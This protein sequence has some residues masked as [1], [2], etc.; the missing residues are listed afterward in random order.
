[1]LRSSG[2]DHRSIALL[3]GC[4]HPPGLLGLR[5]ELAACSLRTCTSEEPW[6]LGKTNPEAVTSEPREPASE[7]S[8]L[9]TTSPSSSCTNERV[10][11]RR[12]SVAATVAPP[13]PGAPRAD[14]WGIVAIFKL[15]ERSTRAGSRAGAESPP[16]DV[17]RARVTATPLAVRVRE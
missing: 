8:K 11:P 17:A 1:M 13:V 16:R 15:L 6:K 2:S 7:P 5:G 4:T 14:A 9:G 10:S 3:L 12:R